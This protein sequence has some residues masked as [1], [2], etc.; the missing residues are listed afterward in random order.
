[1]RD[2]SRQLAPSGSS[3][4]AAQRSA[5]ASDRRVCPRHAK[6]RP[7]QALGAAA[8]ASP[9]P[10]TIRPAA[11]TRRRWCAAGARPGRGEARQF[12]AKAHSSVPHRRTTVAGGAVHSCGCRRP[13]A[14]AAARANGSA[15]VRSSSGVAATASA[16]PDEAMRPKACDWSRKRTL[17]GHAFCVRSSRMRGTSSRSARARRSIPVEAWPTASRVRMGKAVAF[18]AQE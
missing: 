4:A 6:P 16:M 15:R 3:C 7:A 12:A 5:R 10:S 9:T 1:M 13:T 18:T 14:A 17:P 8:A 11:A 2:S